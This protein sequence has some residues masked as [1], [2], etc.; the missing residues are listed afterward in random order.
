MK[1]ALLLTGFVRT[2]QQTFPSIKQFILD[3]YNPDVYI[4]SWDKTQLRSLENYDRVD[5]QG[6]VETY[7]DWLVQCD[8]M[9]HDEYEQM[10]PP[11][12]QFI[13]RPNDVFKVNQRA[14]EHGSYWV[15]RLRDQW[16]AVNNAFSMIANDKIYDR[17]I[18]VRFDVHF[19]NLQ[20]LDETFVIPKDIGGWCYSD[21]LAYGNYET[22]SKYCSIYNHLE[23][24][25]REHNID[26]THSVDM[27]KFYM[28]Q[29]QNPVKTTIDPSIQYTIIK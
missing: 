3:K 16:F 11:P 5:K 7:K 19:Y 21:H 4:S 25:Y 23:N 18:R 10:K 1:V 26:I 29:Y 13:D 27:L 14:I 8:F 17:I 20:F 9:D 15:E 22:M 6:V 24:M 2:Y 28:E 12:I